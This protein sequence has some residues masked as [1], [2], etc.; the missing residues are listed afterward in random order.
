M[1]LLSATILLFYITGFQ[2]CYARFPFREKHSAA[3]ISAVKRNAQPSAW[4][5][6]H[7]TFYEGD[8]TTF[9]G[10]CDYKDVVT[11][12]YGYNTTALSGVLFNEGQ[13]CGACYELRCARN[14]QWCKPGQPSLIL[15]ATDHCPPNPSLPND[16]G[17]WCNHPREHFDI[18]KPVFAQLANHTAGIIPV[19]YRR[20]P[21][22]RNGGIQFTINGNQWFYDVIIWNVAAAGDL[23]GVD[24][25]G[26]NKLLHWVEME[27]DW[28]STWKTK[29]ILVNESLSFRLIASDDKTLTSLNVTPR[30][31]QFGQ[32]YQAH[33]NFV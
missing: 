8:S 33:N 11:Q 2:Y 18:A 7:A 12:G 9:G 31:W 24:V 20:V 21:C 17:G 27:R 5:A 32:T 28:G 29:S 16:N 19:D 13:T 1:G 22:K 10:A 4:T 6:A 30:N 25:K 15:T 14:P 23:D 3:T 26:D